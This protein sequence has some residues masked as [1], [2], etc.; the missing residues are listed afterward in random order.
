MMDYMNLDG[1]SRILRTVF[2]LDSLEQWTVVVAVMCFADQ[3]H[4][5]RAFGGRNTINGLWRF[6]RHGGI[7]TYQIVML[8]LIT[9][10]NLTSL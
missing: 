7:I 9:Q 1:A 8:V 4:P 5:F 6:G 10:I 3:R 2:I